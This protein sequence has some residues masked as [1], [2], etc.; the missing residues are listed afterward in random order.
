MLEK[1][2]K[3]LTRV[4]CNLNGIDFNTAKIWC[5]QEDRFGNMWLGC[6]SKGLVIIPHVQPQ[7]ASWRFSSQGYHVS[8]TVTSIMASSGVS[9]KEME[10]MA[11]TS[12]AISF[13]IL[14]RQHPRRLCIVTRTVATGYAPMKPSMPII[15][16]PVSLSIRHHLF[17]RS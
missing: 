12:V 16:L 14:H 17:A 9:S 11:L 13:P 7:F 15:P 8:S 2:S 10:F 1:G 3:K 5:I 4:E 6:Q